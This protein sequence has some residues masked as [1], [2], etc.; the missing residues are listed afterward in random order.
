MNMFVVQQFPET[1]LR[2][3]FPGGPLIVIDRYVAY[4]LSAELADMA[5]ILSVSLKCL[6]IFHIAT[7]HIKEMGALSADQQVKLSERWNKELNWS[8]Q[9]KNFPHIVAGVDIEDP[10]FWST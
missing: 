8:R 7:K 2:Q 9:F 5:D 3:A 6:F 1:E 10:D 4:S